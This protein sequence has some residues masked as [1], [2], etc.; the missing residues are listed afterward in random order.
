MI[1]RKNGI[2]LARQLLDLEEVPGC[3]YWQNTSD[4]DFGI[5][6]CHCQV[7]RVHVDGPFVGHYQAPLE[8]TMTIEPGQRLTIPKGWL[9]VP[10]PRGQRSKPR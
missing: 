5:I 4:I 2:V 10:F 9:H 7:D 8:Q 6:K 1:F 3:K